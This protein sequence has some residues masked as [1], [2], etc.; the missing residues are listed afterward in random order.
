MTIFVLEFEIDWSKAMMKQ[1][2]D[3]T[4]YLSSQAEAIINES[5]IDDI[6]E[7]ICL[8]IS[9]IQKSLGKGL[10]WIIDSIVDHTITKGIRSKKKFNTQNIDYNEWFQWLLVRFLHLVDHHPAKLEELTKILRDILTLT[11]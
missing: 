7:S 6:F 9:N 4:F 1:N 8:M 2:I 3:N 10:G 5:D 11:T